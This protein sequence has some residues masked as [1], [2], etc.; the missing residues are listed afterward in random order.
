MGRKEQ[1]RLL[2]THP[3]FTGYADEGG[4]DLRHGV[5]RAECLSLPEA[6]ESPQAGLVVLVIAEEGWDRNRGLEERLQW[7]FCLLRAEYNVLS[8]Y[9]Q[10]S[11]ALLNPLRRFGIPVMKN[12]GTPIAR[13]IV[14]VLRIYMCATTFPHG[15]PRRDKGRP[16]GC[17]L[18]GGRL[19]ECGLAPLFRESH[20]DM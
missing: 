7:K 14:G 20:N 11:T 19:E 18:G 17:G 9:V 12:N 4:V 16:T 13:A 2:A 15:S 5:S 10:S 6:K 3:V 8:T 1:H